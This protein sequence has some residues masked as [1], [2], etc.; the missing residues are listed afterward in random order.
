M[1]HVI[2]CLC[3]DRHCIF[4]MAYDPADISPEEAMQGF[5][6]V[7]Q[8]ALDRQLA[9]PHCGICGSTAWQYEDRATKFKT[10]EE[11]RPVLEESERAQAIARAVL[12]KY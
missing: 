12:G 10:I 5:R 1:I 6:E 4:G 11:A 7:V 8:A 9:N 3:P 2:Q